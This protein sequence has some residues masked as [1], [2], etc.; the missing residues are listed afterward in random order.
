MK[1]VL[2]DCDGTLVDSAGIIHDCMVSTFREAGLREPELA[3]TK[4]IIGLTL[5]LAIAR[6]LDRELDAEIEQLTARY[7]HH[8]Q[9]HRLL[10]GFHEPLYDGIAALL[11]SIAR[12]DDLL[13]GMVTGKSRRGVESVFATHG[14]GNQFI[15]VRTAD[16]CPSKPHP[17]MVL[18]CCAEAGIDPASTIVVGDAIYDMQ[19]ARSAGAKALGVAWGYHH[20]EGLTAAGAHAIL[21]TPAD[22]TAHLGKE[23]RYA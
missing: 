6:L 18:E 15:A 2:F 21:R 13:V 10:P 5:N 22:L 1:L 3:E 16:D 7:K 17:A 11:E 14:F 4:G 19:M 8:F 23:T 12:R 9:A 20:A